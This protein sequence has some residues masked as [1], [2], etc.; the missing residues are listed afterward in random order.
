MKTG[1]PS[2]APHS[3]ARELPEWARLAWPRLFEMVRAFEPDV[4]VLTARKMP[5]ICESMQIKFGN[6]VLVISDFAI[7]FSSDYL[8]NARVAIVDDVVNI[9][10][11][12]EQ[13][14]GI[15]EKHSPAAVKLFSLA[16]RTSTGF[17]NVR[18]ISFAHSSPLAGK[19]FSAYVRTVPAAISHV[20]KP[21]DLVF[22]VVRARYQIPFHK[23]TEITEW[24]RSR[25]DSQTI[26]VIPTPYA[27]SPIRRVSIL[28]N[29]D[30]NSLP[31]KLRLYFDDAK[32]ECSIVPMVVPHHVAEANMPLSLTWVQDLRAKLKNAL[33][34]RPDFENSDALAAAALFTSSLDWFWSSDTNAQLRDVFDFDGKPFCPVD[35]RAAFGPVIESVSI[36]GSTSETPTGFQSVANT[37]VKSS[38]IDKFDIDQLIKIAVSRLHQKGITRSETGA[39]YYSY[40]LS[41]VEALSELVGTENPSNYKVT[42]PY[43]REEIGRNPYL[44][45]RIGPSFPDLVIICGRLHQLLTK[46]EQPPPNSVSLLSLMLDTLID[47][48]AIV[49][50][51]ANYDG[52]IFRIYRRGEGPGQDTCEPVVYAFAAHEKPLSIVRLAKI[53]SVLSHSQ[54]YHGMLN[55]SA[56]PRGLV[57]SV[58]KTVLAAEPDNIATYIRNTGQI[59]TV[60]K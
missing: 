29:G 7:P 35:A 48:G 34:T 4:V 3:A 16:R 14:T 15:V 49:P 58:P 20:C 2:L 30:G 11:T 59:K 47:Q 40:L 55:A 32:A 31:K 56:Q 13:V 46:S 12:L 43:T 26:Q 24:L 18:Q 41:I 37:Q 38:F 5:R 10:S 17:Q 36:G 60:E 28:L 21:Y 52:A 45:L 39:D 42:W 51:F 27:N 57:G 54:K 22:P 50:T 23:A 9:G 8:T 53:L 44:R 6:Q 25:F 19:D 33:S 1:N